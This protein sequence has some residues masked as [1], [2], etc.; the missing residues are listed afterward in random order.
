[1]IGVQRDIDRLALCLHRPTSSGV[2]RA[3][4]AI[5]TRV[6]MRTTLTWSIAASARITARSRRAES[7][8]GSPP[9]RIT[10]QISE[11]PRM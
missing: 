9:V 3:G 4:S 6:W 8:S 5:G 2:M 1:M 11:W 7:T 10:S